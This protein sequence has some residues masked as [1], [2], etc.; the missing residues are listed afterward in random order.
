MTRNGQLQSDV[1][2]AAWSKFDQ[3]LTDV[4]AGFADLLPDDIE[5]LISQALIDARRSG[6]E[7]SSPR[8]DEGEEAD[9]D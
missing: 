1:T 7:A 8:R 6:R 2:E 9:P 3:T 4:R 5:D